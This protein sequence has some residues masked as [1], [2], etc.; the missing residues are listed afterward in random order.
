MTAF[1]N[2]TELSGILEQARDKAR[3]DS[4]QWATQKVANSC[5]NWLNKI[6]TFGKWKDRNFQFDDTNHTKLP[7]GT[8]NL[9]AAQSDYSFLVDEQGNRITNI[10]RIDVKDS[11]GNWTKL[12]LIDQKEVTVALDE[13]EPTAGVPKYYD[14]IADNIVRL[15]PSPISSVTAGLKFYFQRT[16]SY[17]V[18][19][20]TTKEPGVSN[21][22]HEGF[23]V[24]AAYDAAYTL[25]LD[26]LP[27]L[28][29]ELQREEKKLE[30]YFASRNTDATGRM[31][32]K[33]ESCR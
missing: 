33:M 20:D 13:F 26:N 6:F 4:T 22:L 31:T 7:I 2:P 12:S 1:S 5:N 9:V 19:T 30:D 11:D 15:Y 21:D 17:F 23:I 16:P 14:K 10:T 29:R 3:V 27:A 25:G 24:K 32:P 28:E 18:A 8:T